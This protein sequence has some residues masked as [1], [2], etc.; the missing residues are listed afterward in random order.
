MSKL[1]ALTKP[2][3]LLAT[4]FGSGYLPK[5]PGTWGS[6]AAIPPGLVLLW[7]GGIPVLLGGIVV[8]T[9]LG[10]WA[11]RKFDEDHGT[12]DSKMIVIDEV[13]GQWIALIPVLTAQGL[14]PLLTVLAFLLFRLFDITKPWPISYFDSQVKGPLGVMGDDVIAGLAALICLYGALYAG[15]G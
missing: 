9:A 13:A 2:H 1:R 10:F 4:W 11:S 5:A 14:S 12:H 8:V 6:V 3:I 7:L 15:F